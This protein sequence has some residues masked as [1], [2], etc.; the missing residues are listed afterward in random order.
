MSKGHTAYF[1]TVRKTMYKNYIL[2]PSKK[3]ATMTI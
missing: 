2:Y 3:K 1:D